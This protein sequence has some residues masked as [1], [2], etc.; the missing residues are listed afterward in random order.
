MPLAPIQRS[1][2]Y[3]RAGADDTIRLKAEDLKLTG[4]LLGE[5]EREHA[6]FYTPPVVAAAFGIL[7][8]YAIFI[9]ILIAVG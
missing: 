5:D 2:T 1:H 6:M 9:A 8:A 7:L 3:G 4:D